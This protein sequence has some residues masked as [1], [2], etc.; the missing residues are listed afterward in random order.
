MPGTATQSDFRLD[1]TLGTEIQFRRGERIARLRPYV[2]I[3]NALSHRDALF[4][5]QEGNVSQ[6]AQELAR[7]PATPTIGLRWDF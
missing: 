1:A 7:L 2:R 4:Y 5:F 6:P 3:V